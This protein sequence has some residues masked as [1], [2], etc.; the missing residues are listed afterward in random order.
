MPEWLIAF[1]ESLGINRPLGSG[2]ISVVV[3]FLLAALATWLS[4][5]AVRRFSLSA[6][7]ADQPN[8]RRINRAPVP[9]AGGLAVYAGTLA[10]L[11]LATLLRPI[12]IAEVKAEVLAI[13]LGGS[14]LVLTGFID[15][16]FHLPP[17]FRLMVQTLA[18]LL[19]V[20][21]GIRIEVGFGGDFAPFLSGLF[22]VVWVVAITNAINLID[23]VDGL[24]G[25][26]SFI[27]GISLLAVAAQFTERAASTI[28]LAAVAGAALGFLRHNFHP[29]AIILGDSGAYF[30][31]FVLAATSILGN[32]KVT[33]IAGLVPTGLFLLLPVADTVQVFFRRLAKRKNPLSTPG[34]DHLHHHLL[35]R[36]F[37]QRRTALVLW[38]VTL[39][40][41]LVAMAVQGMSAVVITTTGVGIVVMLG[42][43]VWRKGMTARLSGVPN[44]TAPY[45]GAAD[46]DH[47]F[48]PGE[49]G[50][51]SK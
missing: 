39:T 42:L 46:T 11:I 24:A 26:V 18:A 20:A 43:V 32:V 51:R 25:G 23:G 16:Q 7:W 45:S 4:I 34:Q 38:A 9:N 50:D 40:T 36:G 41:N 33:T 14:V 37:S 49:E 28:L 22:T 29:S 12:I 2:W 10:A 6:G 17:V 44:E 1:L 13:L 8:H 35:A 19:L 3:T 27:V 21:T 31:G 5:P 30:L 47:E 48:A 15:D